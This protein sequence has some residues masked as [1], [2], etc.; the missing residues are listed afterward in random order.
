MLE[1]EGPLRVVML[2]PSCSPGKAISGKEVMGEGSGKGRWLSLP[3][4]QQPEHLYPHP[5]GSRASLYINQ[6][7]LL[8]KEGHT[9]LLNPEREG[10]KITAVINPQGHQAGHS[11]RKTLHHWFTITGL[12]HVSHSEGHGSFPLAR[13]DTAAGGRQGWDWSLSCFRVLSTP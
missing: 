11:R 2:T 3:A 13:P 8:Q 6:G 7:L 9:T 4:S 10:T 1:L 5:G 12:A